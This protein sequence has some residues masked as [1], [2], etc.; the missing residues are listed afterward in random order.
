MNANLVLA[1]LSKT[2]NLMFVELAIVTT[3]S[4]RIANLSH[5]PKTTSLL[6]SHSVVLSVLGKESMSRVLE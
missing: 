1:L 2:S 6:S 4:P 5:N 3:V